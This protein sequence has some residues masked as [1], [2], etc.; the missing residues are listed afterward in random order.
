MTLGDQRAF[1]SVTL[2]SIRM[3]GIDEDRVN[4]TAAPSRSAP[5][6]R[7][8]RAHLGSS[9]TSYAGAVKV[10]AARDL[11]RRRS[12]DAV[13]SGRGIAPGSTGDDR[14]EADTRQ[15]RG[16]ER[17]VAGPIGRRSLRRR[18]SASAPAVSRPNGAG[19]GAAFFDLDKT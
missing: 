19:H 10:S 8:R 17:R 11:L 13:I 7:I 12:G 1:A 15:H 16:A 9:C 5:D 6:R 2:N 18:R 3:L 4:V 14:C